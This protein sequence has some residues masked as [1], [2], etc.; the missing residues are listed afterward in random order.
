MKSYQNLRRASRIN[1]KEVEVVGVE[2]AYRG[3]R[4]HFNLFLQPQLIPPIHMNLITKHTLQP[5][6]LPNQLIVVFRKH[7]RCPTSLV[8]DIRN[9]VPGDHLAR[10]GRGVVEEDLLDGSPPPHTVS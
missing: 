1:M 5:T 7:T 3:L 6:Q 10:G 9:D 8:A 4:S 2:R